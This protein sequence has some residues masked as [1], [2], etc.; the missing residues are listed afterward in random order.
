MKDFNILTEALDQRA[1]GTIDVLDYDLLDGKKATGRVTVRDY[2]LLA[3]KTV[4]VNGTVLTEGVNWTAAVDNET[5]A[6]T[7]EIAIE[8]VTNIDSTVDGAVINVTAGAIGAAG[9]AYTLATNAAADGLTVS[10]ATLTGGQ[11]AGT[12]TI[13]PDTITEGADFNAET[14]N[15]VTATNIAA[16]IA[17]LAGVS[18]TSNGTTVTIVND[19]SGTAG[20]SVALLT[21]GSGSAVTLSAA[22]L[23]GGDAATYSDPVDLSV[24]EELKNVEIVGFLTAIAG[25]STPTIT[26]TPQYSMDKVNWFDH[27]T[28]FSTG[29]TVINTPQKLDLDFTALFLRFKLVNSGVDCVGTFRVQ[30]VAK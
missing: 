28:S 12:F 9:N 29:F 10:G 22:T 4:T 5:T 17:A 7:L 24:V 16:A 2:T 18:A 11:D 23:L 15:A 21:N 25:S 8:A 13:G 3:G 26:A 20:N 27:T 14:S 1:S 19:A 6:A 30:G